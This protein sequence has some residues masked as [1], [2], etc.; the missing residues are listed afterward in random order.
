[1]RLY[2]W[3]ISLDWRSLFKWQFCYQREVPPLLCSCQTVKDLLITSL[4]SF[5][6]NELNIRNR[7]A[8]QWCWLSPARHQR[9]LH[10]GNVSSSLLAPGWQRGREGENHQDINENSPPIIWRQECLGSPMLLDQTETIQQT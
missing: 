10:S 9:E 4:D 3:L 6:N 5:G 2:W 1:M 7:A 8:T